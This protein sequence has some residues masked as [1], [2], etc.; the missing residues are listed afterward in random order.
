MLKAVYLVEMEKLF[1]R[2]KY[3]VFL[4]LDLLFC[5]CSAVGQL[6]AEIVSRGVLDTSGLFDMMHLNGFSIYQAVFLVLIV[7]LAS[8]DLFSSE[9]HDLSIRMLLQRPVERWKIYL[10]KNAAVFSL[11]VIYMLAHFVF[12]FLVKLIFGQTAVGTFS[13][14]GTYIIDLVPFIVVVLFFSFLNQLVRSVGSSVAL[15]VVAYLAVMAF[16]RYANI[17]AGLVFTEFIGWHSLWFGITLPLSVL[18]PKIGILL[19]TGM[20]FYCAGFELFDRKEI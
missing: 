10:G 13:A 15:S 20:L 1:C 19:G 6:F 14:L 2:K 18:L 9:I 4:I 12:L 8:S 3:L 7:L 17:S 16:G 5:I 11:V